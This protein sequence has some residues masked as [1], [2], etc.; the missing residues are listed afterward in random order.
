M[1]SKGPKGPIR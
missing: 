1:L